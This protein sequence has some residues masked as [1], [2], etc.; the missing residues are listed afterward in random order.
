[1]ARPTFLW[2][3]T[4][5][6]ARCGYTGA[7]DARVD[8][9]RLAAAAVAHGVEAFLPAI[10]SGT[11]E[12]WLLNEHYPHDESFLAA[13]ADV[14]H[15]EFKAITDAG[16]VLQVD[17]PDLPDSWQ[18][19]PDM[20]VP[21]YRRYAAL[22]VEALN[23]ALRGIPPSTCDCTSAGAATTGRTGTTSCCATSSILCFPSRRAATPTRGTRTIGSSGRTRNSPTAPR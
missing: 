17:D 12:H 3:G 8:I 10:T 6:P 21:E 11:V 14:L 19:F 16:L 7:A 5:A 13:I 4:V 18:M 15:E 9:D 1:M 2:R 22:R 20:T 23:H